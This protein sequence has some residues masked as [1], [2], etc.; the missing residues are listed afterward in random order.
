MFD[1]KM[2]SQDAVGR[3]P[4]TGII[5]IIDPTSKLIGLRLYQGIFKV[6]F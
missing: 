2:P 1:I 4:E 6:S 5:G 3:P